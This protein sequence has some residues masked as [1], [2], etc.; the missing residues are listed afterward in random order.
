MTRDDTRPGT[1]PIGHVAFLTLYKG[2]ENP[3]HGILGYKTEHKINKHK[4]KE[5]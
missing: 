3:D 4:I 1:R 5:R 2:H